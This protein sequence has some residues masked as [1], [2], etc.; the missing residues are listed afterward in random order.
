MVGCAWNG[1]TEMRTWMDGIHE[2]CELVLTLLLPRPNNRKSYEAWSA[3]GA[4]VPLTLN[5]AGGFQEVTFCFTGGWIPA[6]P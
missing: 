3:Y 1:C 5:I 6:L 4:E 2:G